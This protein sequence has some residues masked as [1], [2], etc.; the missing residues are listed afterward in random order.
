MNL[1]R[2]FSLRFIAGVL[3]LLNPVV[4]L[5]DILPDFVGFLLIFSALSE[6][7]FLD[8][9]FEIARRL[10]LY[11]ALVSAARTGLMFFSLSMDGC[12]VLSA[13]SILGVAELFVTLYF[14]SV[15][16][17][18]IEYIALR[19]ESKNTL[20]TAGK[21]RT[22]SKV[23]WIIHTVSTFV[24]ELAALV[25]L[26]MQHDPYAYPDL[27]DRILLLYKN[28]TVILLFT[29]SLM[30]GIWWFVKNIKFMRAAKSEESF[31]A[32]LSKRYGEFIR[33]NP[34]QELF[35]STRLA[36]VLFC[37]GCALQF[38][39]EIDDIAFLPA[40][41]GTVLIAISLLAIKSVRR[42]EY[43]IIAAAAVFQLAAV[44]IPDTGAFRYVNA[45]LL[46][47]GTL[48]AVPAAQK[49]F[50]EKLKSSLD[51][52]TEGGF[53]LADIP[54][55]LFAICSAIYN[56]HP[57]YWMRFAALILYIVWMFLTVKICVSAA[58]E[59]KLRRRL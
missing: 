26:Q 32:E 3:F 36:C 50:S 12:A 10:T 16:F 42:N 19:S 58:V 43:I 25:Q 27:D 22:V 15:F 51:I 8:A 41:A 39:F 53:I 46:A 28:G 14:T 4:G 47:I 30:A 38:N 34:L 44:C 17:N 29:V 59:I 13:V 11:G 5:F 48:A 52:E 1:K 20:E 56:M 7:A 6:L 57:W 21:V 2:F 45:A 18:G 37:I 40:W 54:F 9:R 35:L 31:K 49:L 33:T 23:F 24:P 55:L